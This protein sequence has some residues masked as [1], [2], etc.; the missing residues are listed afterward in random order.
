MIEVQPTRNVD[1]NIIG[2]IPIYSVLVSLGKINAVMRTWL[3]VDRKV[4][5]VFRRMAR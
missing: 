3:G 1:I 5:A 4:M 2:Q